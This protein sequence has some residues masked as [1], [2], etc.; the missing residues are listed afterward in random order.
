LHS[1]Q[2]RSPARE[3]VLAG[4]APQ[5]PLLVVVQGVP[6]AG[7]EPAGHKVQFEHGVKPVAFQVRPSWHVAAHTCRAA[8]QA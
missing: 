1:V 3:K 8:L 7:E 2:A 6:A 5:T 4:Q